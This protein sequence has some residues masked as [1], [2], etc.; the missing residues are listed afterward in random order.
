MDYSECGNYVSLLAEKMLALRS[1][2]VAIAI[3]SCSPDPLFGLRAQQPGK[4]TSFQFKTVEVVGGFSNPYDRATF[5]IWTAAV[6]LLSL[7]Y[8]WYVFR[9]AKKGTRTKWG[10]LP[11]TVLFSLSIPATPVAHYMIINALY[12]SEDSS[13]VSVGVWGGPPSLLSWLT[14]TVLGAV[15]FLIYKSLPAAA[16]KISQEDN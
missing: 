4:G 10:I 13:I 2:S 8:L 3:F 11:A 9:W 12:V 15:I 1:Y 14:G 16:P 5:L 6:L 7:C